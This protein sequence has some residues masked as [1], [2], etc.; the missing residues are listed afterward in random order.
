MQ[1]SIAGILV[2]L[3]FLVAGCS[4]DE[5]TISQ[6]DLIEPGTAVGHLEICFSIDTVFDWYANSPGPSTL[7]FF[8][9]GEY[10]EDVDS[11]YVNSYSGVAGNS[12]NVWGPEDSGLETTLWQGEVADLIT[13]TTEDLPLGTYILT[14]VQTIGTISPQETFESHIVEVSE[15]SNAYMYEFPLV[16]P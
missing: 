9:Q 6:P 4:P 5:I 12:G 15:G 7:A 3:F 8:L 16:A 13:W 14:V 1:R 10:Y 11:D 2:L